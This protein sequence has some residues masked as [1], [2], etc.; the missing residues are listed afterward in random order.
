MKNIKSQICISLTVLLAVWQLACDRQVSDSITAIQPLDG[1]T[2]G[3]K[4]TASDGSLPGTQPGKESKLCKKG[5]DTWVG[6]DMTTYGNKV[7]IWNDAILQ[8]TLVTVNCLNTTSAEFLPNI[9]FGSHK[10]EVHLSFKYAGISNGEAKLMKIYWLDPSTNQWVLFESTPTVD[11]NEK[12][13][14]FTV[15]HFSIYAFGR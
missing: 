2:L 14:I 15:P 10:P 1:S 7:M 13:F 5:A 6:S 12:A 4:G 8:D 11:D 3:K 9:T